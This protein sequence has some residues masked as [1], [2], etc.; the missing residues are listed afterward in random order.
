MSEKER[1]AY[2]RYMTDFEGKL[3][4]AANMLRKEKYTLEEITEATGLGE[5]QV[6]ELEQQNRDD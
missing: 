2:Q 5:D 1:K 4:I 3:E 6:R